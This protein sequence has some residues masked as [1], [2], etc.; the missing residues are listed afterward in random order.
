MNQLPSCAPVSA[1]PEDATEP[2]ANRLDW[3]ACGWSQI[4]T[5]APTFHDLPEFGHASPDTYRVVTHPDTPIAAGRTRPDQ[6]ALAVAS[7]LAAV[8][9]RLVSHGLSRIASVLAVVFRAGSVSGSV[10]GGKH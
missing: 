7:G 9:A 3:R 6:Q 5:N 4:G 8:R 2:P 1:C 10:L